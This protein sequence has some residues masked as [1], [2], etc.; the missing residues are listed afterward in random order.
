[1]F[2]LL[3]YSH[4]GVGFGPYH[5]DLDVYRI[6]GQAWLH[7]EDLYGH[8]PATSA[9]ARLPFTYPPVAAFLLAPFSLVPMAVAATV[10]TFATIVLLAVALRVFLRRLTGPAAGSWWAIAWLL[11]AGLLLEPV[12]D[13]LGFGQVNVVLMALVSLDCLA[14]TPRWPRGALVG[15]AA[16]VKLTPA[17]FVLFFLVRRDLR[18]A[19]TVACSFAAVA[20]LGFAVAWHD[21][22]QYWTGTAF[23]VSRAGGPGAASNQSILA[24]LARAGL[25]PHTPAAVAAWLAL[26]AV[27]VAFAWRRMSQA[28]AAAE[29]CLA[30]SLNAF[31]ALLISPV[32]WS[33][34]WAWCAPAVL[35]FT[36]RG[37]SRRSRRLLAAGA[38]GL[39]LFAASPQ[40]WIRPGWNADVRWAVWQQLVT[41]PYALF[42]ALILLL[43]CAAVSPVRSIPGSGS[44][45]RAADVEPGDHGQLPAR[46][47]K[48]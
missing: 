17:A 9:G 28:L 11:P 14:E 23:Q 44:T 48:P 22:V 26:S 39:A 2:F 20:A 10:L 36:A 30:L 18:A 8:L 25:G 3:S 13:T 45:P 32:S 35:T 42:A 34:H 27:V 5:I 29:N 38:A 19:G 7:G 24:I 47:D 1:M 6:G 37:V 40:F 41:S 46:R 16:A 15:L 12:R 21:S 33:H 31:A 43:N 4:R